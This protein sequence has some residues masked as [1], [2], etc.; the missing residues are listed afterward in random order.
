MYIYNEYDQKIVDERV[1]Q[2]RDQLNRRLSGAL[3]EDEFKPLRLRNGLYRQLHAYMLR[4]AIPYGLLNSPQLRMLGHI[5]RKYDRG[6]GHFTTRQNIQYNWPKLDESGD[7]LAD[8]ASVQMHAIQ[9]SGNCV[10]N[11]TS[12]EFA[13][14]TPDE[15]EDPRPYCEIVR[16]WSTF[17]PEFN[18]LPRKFKIAV[19]GAEND[20]AAVA[21]HDI[22]MRL[23]RNEA[24]EV[25]FAFYVGGG[26]GRTPFIGKLI[27]PWI[28]KK[29]LLSYLEAIL[30]VYNRYGRRDNLYKSRIKILVHETGEE[31]F[32][33]MVDAEWEQIKASALELTEEEVA[34]VRSHFT[35]PDYKKLPAESEAFELAQSRDPAFKRWVAT[36]VKAHKQS[37]YVAVVISLKVHGEPTGDMTDVQMEAVADLADQFSFGEITVTHKQN[38]VLAHVEKSKVHELYAHLVQLNLANA[39]AGLLTDIICCPGLDYC[40]LANARSINIAN[41]LGVAMDDLDYLH[42][43]GPLRLNISG[44]IN[45]CGHHHVGNIGILGVNKKGEEAYQITLGGSSENDASIGQILGPAFDEDKVVG[46]VQSVVSVYLDNRQE[47][48][49]F[50]DCVRRLGLKPFKERVYAAH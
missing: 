35:D 15:I 39:N 6:Y 25:G 30:R 18:W 8:L 50:L 29:H 1:E 37:G 41:A 9:T 34:R 14:I 12:D 19:T 40:D 13:G 38:L 5:A 42:D 24:G 49:R 3:S 48:E 4:V 28:E 20:R 26:L 21:V 22:G 33:Q 31:K 46:A 36:N 27:R 11:V 10:R 47:D 44:C 45:A 43:L 17:H 7:I 16:Q 23:A 2:Y 32:R